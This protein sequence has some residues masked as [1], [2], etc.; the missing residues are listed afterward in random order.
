MIHTI[1]HNYSDDELLRYALDTIQH[2]AVVEICQRLRLVDFE[3]GDEDTVQY[4][5]VKLDRANSQIDCLEEEI[6]I[7]KEDISNHRNYIESLEADL[8]EANGIPN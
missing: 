2:P 6:E 4:L 8:E 1:Y 5:Q 7:L 3:L